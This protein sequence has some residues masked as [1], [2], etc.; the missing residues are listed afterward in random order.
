MRHLRIPLLLLM[1]SAATA[2]TLQ[3]GIDP[4]AHGDRRLRVDYVGYRAAT[5]ESEF[6]TEP[7]NERPNKGGF[8]RVYLRNVSDKPVRLGF[9]RC[10]GEDE[11]HWRLGGF[12]AWDRIYKENLAA[13]ERTILEIN[14]LTEDF[15]PGKPFSFSYVERE[16]WTPACRHET[17]LN[18]DPVQVSL[19]RVLPGMREI[20]V[21]VRNT[22]KDKV[23]VESLELLD[24]KVATARWTCPEIAG[25]GTAIAGLPLENALT[26]GELITVKLNIA[27]SGKPRSISA[28]RRAYEDWFPVGVWSN[29]PENWEILARHHIDLVVKGGKSDNEFFGRAAAKYGFRAMTSCGRPAN[30]EVIR[31][32]AKHP[33][34]ACWMLDDEPD[35]RTESTI[36]AFIDRS[37]RAYDTSK[38]TFIT[39]CRNVK[40][41]EYAPICDIPCMDHYSV[42]APTSSKWPYRYGTHL[43]ETG[44]YTRDLKRASEPKPIWV[45]SQAIA[46]W[47]E[48]PRRPLPTPNE[49]AMQLVQNLGRGAKGIIWFNYEDE[50]ARKY[51]DVLAA[52]GAWGRVMCVTRNDFLASEPYEADPKAPDK[53]D[54]AALATVDK[55][56]LCLSNS[57]YDI[58]PEAYPFRTQKDVKLSLHIPS[59]IR[60]KCALEVGPDGVVPLEFKATKGKVR[61]SAGDIEAA[62]VIVLANDQNCEPEY[63]QAYKKAIEDETRAF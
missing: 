30:P 22:G 31:D 16:Q 59:W 19:I 6:L 27:D 63:A 53:L 50:V 15:A 10:N 51:P 33:A 47:S 46:T 12:L 1:A 44:Y 25:N 14:A 40:F 24:K 21:H 34:V 54:V 58:H 38:P 55:L 42:T 29:S 43:E 61:V 20:E 3:L 37:V 5:C 9:W 28:H 32:L 13:G 26:P 2:Q 39:L 8:I 62:K 11:S 41:F 18:E 48:R 23:R 57:D 35:W 4:N 60:P 56:I 45:W 7:Q 49:L 36:M 17:T 52:M